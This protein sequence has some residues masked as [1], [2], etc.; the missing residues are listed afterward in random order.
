MTSYA[1]FLKD[2][3]SNRRKLEKHEIVM[4]TEECS[5]RIQKKVPPKLKDHGSFTVPC[6]IE[7]YHFDKA[8]CDLGASTNLIPFFIF[9]KL[10]LGE[11][12]V[13]AVTLQLVD[14]SL[15]HPRGIIEDVLI[16]VGK[17]IFPADFLILDM[18][19]D[20]GVAFILG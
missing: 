14:R 5:V 10:D 20:N 9:R 8:L 16:K 12:K 6:T 11:V 17:I 13:T 18:E 3:L 4:L 7:N 15:T 2:V 19:K 1:K